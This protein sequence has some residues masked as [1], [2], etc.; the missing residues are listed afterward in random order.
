MTLC[1]RFDDQLLQIAKTN[2]LARVPEARFVAPPAASSRVVF[3]PVLS[4]Y[5]AAQFCDHAAGSVGDEQACA[6]H[7]NVRGRQVFLKN[8]RERVTMTLQYAYTVNG[9]SKNPDGSYASAPSPFE[10]AIRVGGEAL[11]E[12][13]ELFRDRH[14]EALPSRK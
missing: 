6:L 2:I 14:G 5:I 7:L 1:A 4:P 8:I 12:H 10:V 13:P 9:F 11:H 3:S